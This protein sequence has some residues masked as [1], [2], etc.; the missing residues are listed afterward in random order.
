MLEESAFL[1]TP[2][3]IFFYPLLFWKRRDYHS[4]PILRLHMKIFRSRSLFPDRLSTLQISVATLERI[5][6]RMTV[7]L[8]YVRCAGVAS[9]LWPVVVLSRRLRR[10]RCCGDFLILCMWWY[11]WRSLSRIRWYRANSSQGKLNKWELPIQVTPSTK[12][13]VSLSPYPLLEY[14]YSSCEQHL[15]NN[16]SLPIIVLSM[17]LFKKV[18]IFICVI[19]IESPWRDHWQ[20]W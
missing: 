2:G 20:E 9:G 14:F 13:C 4:W 10:D 8:L 17:L 16:K 19:S 1:L 11:W 7:V 5:S 15:L 12:K 3:T 18:C 6:F